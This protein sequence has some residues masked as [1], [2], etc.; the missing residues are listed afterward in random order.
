[1]A[2]DGKVAVVFGG[3][4]GIG[5]ATTELFAARGAKVVVADADAEGAAKIAASI[6]GKGGAAL[7]VTADVAQYAA[8]E[9]AVRQA[10]AHYGTLD[11]VFNCAAIVTRKQLLEHEPEDFA[12]IIRVNLEGTFNGLLAGARAMRELGKGGCIINTASVAAY[13]A[14]P[15]M[16]AYHASKGGVRSLTQAA[17]VELAPLGIRVVAVAPGAIDTPLLGDLKEAGLDR[18]LARKQLRRKMIAP[19]KVAE[20]VVFLASDEADAIN[21][22]VVLVDDGYVSFK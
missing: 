8:T 10:V 13:M 15:M 4:G 6:S 16:V 5:R 21:G 7:A 3:A 22:T 18:D 1:V 20:V 11:I 17:A 12:S 19:E 2:V 14:S 9:S